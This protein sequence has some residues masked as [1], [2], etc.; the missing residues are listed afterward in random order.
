MKEPIN[1]NVNCECCGADV[2]KGLDGVTETTLC[3]RCIDIFSKYRAFKAK[4]VEPLAKEPHI[5]CLAAAHHYRLRPAMTAKAWIISLVKIGNRA[6]KFVAH[7]KTFWEA[8]RIVRAYLSSLPD[9]EIPTTDGTKE[10]R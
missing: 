5:I 8:E 1:I 4:A 7:G 9:K 6:D 2:V 10:G 3:I